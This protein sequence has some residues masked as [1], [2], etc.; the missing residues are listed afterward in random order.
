MLMLVRR[1]AMRMAVRMSRER[2]EYTSCGPP[3]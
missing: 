3:P 2:V 1:L